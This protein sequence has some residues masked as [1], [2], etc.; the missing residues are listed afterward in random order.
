MSGDFNSLASF[1]S[2]LVARE[3]AT[4]VALGAGLE[5][6]AKKIEATA[7]DEIGHYQPATGPFPEWAPLADTTEAEKARLGYP[8]DAP[9]LREGQLRDSI[10][11]EVSGLEAVVGSKSDI[12][13]YQEF[14]T[15]TIPPRPFIGPAAFRNQKDI[16]KAVGAAAVLG[17]AGGNPIAQS[18]GY[19]M[20]IR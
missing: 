2:H 10:E 8:S 3:V 20:Q 15:K 16:E 13:A 5:V 9:L 4:V 6:V 14:G 1:A 11:H 17:L 19:D 7:K 12:A 18:L